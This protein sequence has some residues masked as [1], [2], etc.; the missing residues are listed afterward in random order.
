[1]LVVCGV[2][3]ML[4][5]SGRHT[6]AAE[7]EFLR[8]AA[9]DELDRRAGLHDSARHFAEDTREAVIALA[10]YTTLMLGSPLLGPPDRGAI[11]GAS[12]LTKIPVT[13]DDVRAYAMY[14]TGDP[15]VLTGLLYIAQYEFLHRLRT[16]KMHLVRGPNTALASTFEYLEFMVKHALRAHA[17]DQ[18]AS[19]SRHDSAP[20]EHDTR[21][22]AASITPSSSASSRACRC[23]GYSGRL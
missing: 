4:A 12:V 22:R 8:N 2:L 6:S 9:V 15:I 18:K 7:L 21:D 10:A 16:N 20:A 23:G 1:M 13:W 19:D 5:A 3:E 14:S 11:R 17:D